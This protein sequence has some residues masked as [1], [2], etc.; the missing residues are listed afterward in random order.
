MTMPESA[1]PAYA[2]ADPIL[3]RMPALATAVSVAN[4]LDKL[5]V[6]RGANH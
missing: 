6:A 2:P 3:S 1:L 5:V 4:Q